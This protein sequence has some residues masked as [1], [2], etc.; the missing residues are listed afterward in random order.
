MNFLTNENIDLVKW[1]SLIETSCFASPFQTPE[2]YN[3]YKNPNG[4]GAY[5]FAFEEN[6]SYKVLVVVTIKS[7]KGLKSV[8]SKRG[9]IYGGL[10]IGEASI[11]VVGHF[12]YK[13]S[14]YL[15]RKIIYLE[16]RNFFSY[17]KYKQVFLK[18]GWSYEPYL[19][20]QLSLDLVASVNILALFKYNRR[21]EIKKTI[22][23]QVKYGLTKSEKQIEDIYL[24]LK[25][26][27]R[28]KVKLPL[29]NLSY[30][31]NLLTEGILKAF[32]VTDKGKTIGGSFCM[33]LPHKNIYTFYYAGLRD[34]EKDIYPTHLAVLAAMEYAVENSI[35][36][37]D[38]MGA[39]KPNEK[40]GVREYKSQFGGTLVEHGR[41]LYV[42]NQFLYNLG[43][44]AIQFMKK[45]PLNL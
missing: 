43:K 18:S 25:D 6:Q 39:G 37:F 36:M 41:F 33:V 12:I 7:E 15:K 5:V 28:E 4:R 14:N 26:L 20:V 24:I 32:V 42:S 21:H 11:D 13:I 1:Q 10:L 27:Y 30:F 40:Y 17:E 22:A 38:F 23:K 45:M 34:Y 44:K 35:P 31:N 2:F 9:I 8:F 3:V 29:P 16:S 19:N